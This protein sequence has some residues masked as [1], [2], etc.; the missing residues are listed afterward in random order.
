MIKGYDLRLGPD[1]DLVLG[2][3]GVAETVTG[4]EMVAQD[5]RERC[6]ILAGS[7]PWDRAAGTGVVRALNARVD[8]GYVAA[9]LM[10]AARQ[11][12]RVRYDSVF[13]RRRGDE[14]EL[15]FETIDGDPGVIDV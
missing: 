2:D 13:A 4:A 1:R 10:R 14:Y 6:Y 9:E 8:D 11:D 12:A 7:L 3:D 15:T 5:V